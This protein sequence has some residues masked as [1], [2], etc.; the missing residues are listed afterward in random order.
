MKS[1]TSLFLSIFALVFVL[2]GCSDSTGQDYDQEIAQDRTE[3]R[4][5][6][7]GDDDDWSEHRENFGDRRTTSSRSTNDNDWGSD[8]KDTDWNTNDYDNEIDEL[9]RELDGLVDL[10]ELERK[11]KT[12]EREFEEEGNAEGLE[13]LENAFESL[14][15]AF[16]E[17]GNA[18][19]NGIE[20]KSVDYDELKGVLPNR[21][22]GYEKKNFNGDK[23]SVFGFNLSVLEQE[24]ES[25]RGNGSLNITVID[26]GSLANAALVGLDWLDLE[27]K[28]E[29]STGFEQTTT[30]DGYPAFEQCDRSSRKDNCSLHLVVEE[31][32]VVQIES[33]EMGMNDIK[34]VLDKMDI[35]KLAE[36][37]EEGI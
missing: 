21:I 12:I 30:I 9:K 29:S 17:V 23:V 27:I 25:D 16:S 32:F 13:E 1:A 31:R 18:I 4:S 2:A 10:D 11:L 6:R 35:R 37:R 20:V 5:Q 33:D 28:S 19:S 34:D 8:D 3:K 14:G 22:R 36:M 24:Y 15:E 7:G 26:L